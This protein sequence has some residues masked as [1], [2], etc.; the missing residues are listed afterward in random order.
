[1]P[2]LARLSRRPERTPTLNGWGRIPSALGVD[3]TGRG[4]TEVGPEC[5]GFVNFDERRARL[6]AG[7]AWAAGPAA[8]DAAN[9]AH[10]RHVC[11]TV[12]RLG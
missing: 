1:M 3:D 11:V 5:A 8:D 9:R 7:R 4:V 10:N 6:R 2:E 12:A